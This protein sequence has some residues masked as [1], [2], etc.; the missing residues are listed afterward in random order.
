M[1][2]LIS[3]SEVCL[4]VMEHTVYPALF[5]WNCPPTQAARGAGARQIL[6]S[7]RIF[8]PPCPLEGFT[9]SFSVKDKITESC[10][11]A[12]D[13]QTGLLL[14]GGILGE[15]EI[16]PERLKDANNRCHIAARPH[17]DYI[18]GCH[19][20]TPYRGVN[21]RKDCFKLNIKTK[22]SSSTVNNKYC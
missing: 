16:F 17:C 12:T 10:Y 1:R 2:Q 13:A 19:N 15:G 11:T 14:I 21:K 22:L 9:I 3:L 5:L 4:S 6:D 7:T 8:F 18:D 20:R